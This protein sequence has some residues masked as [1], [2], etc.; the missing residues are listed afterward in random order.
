[1]QPQTRQ[2]ATAFERLALFWRASQWLAA[3]DHGLNPSQ[4]DVLQRIA[5]QP[6]RAADLALRLG[7]SQAS[8]SDTVSALVA[9]GMA[10]RKPDPGDG[11]ARLIEAIPHAATWLP[12]EAEVTPAEIMQL[13]GL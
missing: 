9:K 2:I 13:L 11:R 4:G 6:E 7:I 1:M 8:L 5:R 3:K 12:C 10:E